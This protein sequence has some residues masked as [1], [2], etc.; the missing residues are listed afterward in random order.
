MDRESELGEDVSVESTEAERDG[1][2][3]AVLA[4]IGM[5]DRLDELKWPSLGWC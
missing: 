3:Q 2:D 4:T 5:E 1:L